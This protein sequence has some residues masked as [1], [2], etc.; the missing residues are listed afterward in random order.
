MTRSLGALLLP[1]AFLLTSITPSVIFMIFSSGSFAPGTAICASGWIIAGIL[2]G[3]LR[4]RWTPR[5]CRTI[6]L[7]LL[8]VTLL[9]VHGFVVDLWLGGVNFARL[10]GSCL[11]LLLMLFGAYSLALRLLAA[12][13]RLIANTGRFSFTVLTLVG[14]G[15]LAGIPSVNNE[16]FAKP[17]IFFSEP[18]HFN[19]AYLPLLIFTLAMTTR[20]RQLLLIGIALFL[21]LKLQNLTMLVGT[22]GASCLVLRRLQLFIF[23]G[24]GVLVLGFVALDLSYFVDRLALSA[25]S[26]NL[27]T[28]VYLQGWQR[29]GLNLQETWGLGVGFQQFGI[30]GSLGDLASRIVEIAGAP[31]N[32]Y[33][34]GSTGSKLIA[35]LGTMGIVAIA[36]FMAVAVRGVGFIRISLRLPVAQRD[37][38]SIF[39]YSFVVAYIG[40][41][42]IRGTGYLSSSGFLILTAFI[43]L[44]R[45][46]AL[47]RRASDSAIVQTAP[48]GI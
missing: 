48:S 32:L 26:D 31:L 12:S 22:L 41:L 4:I 6:G 36:I 35:E 33:D 38:K 23:L 16:T 30:V 15:A 21:A 45:L 20:V 8:L 46:R 44:P 39:F 18:S 11:T 19:L 17:V 1:P 14:Y 10:V 3:K 29:A 13:P 25:D 27:S 24:V 9:V 37:V 47:T 5:Q 2:A 42:F 40:E 43:A 28:L 7:I 34:G